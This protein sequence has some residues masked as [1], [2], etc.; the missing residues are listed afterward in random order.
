MN[1]TLEKIGELGL[2]PVVKIEKTE[3]ALPLG[4]ALITYDSVK[5]ENENKE[6]LEHQFITTSC[7]QN[8]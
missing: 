6:V 1:Q 2:V 5:I 4:I 8:I 3:D 7:I